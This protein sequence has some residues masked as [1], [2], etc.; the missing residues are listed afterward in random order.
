M[1][2]DGD[3]VLAR[4]IYPVEGVLSRDIT[5]AIA[6]TQAALLVV[7]DIQR[8]AVEV[9]KRNETITIKARPGGHTGPHT[10]ALAW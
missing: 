9:L 1:A 3:N 2:R 4:A 6:E 5:N 7:D 10:T 8:D